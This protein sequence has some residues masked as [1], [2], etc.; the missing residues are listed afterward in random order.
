MELYNEMFYG[1]ALIKSTDVNIDKR[2]FT[3]T[4]NDIT[5]D[6]SNEVLL[7]SG[8]QK[9]NFLKN[10][11]ILFGH[12]S[13]NPIGTTI[14]LRRKGDSWVAKGKIAEEGTCPNID[15][16]WKLIKQGVLKACS[17]GLMR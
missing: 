17:V 16:Y 9:S 11:I 8:M 13:L 14:S 4:I 3:A 12:N 5:V 7:P 2:E 6:R 15:K 1:K 10:G